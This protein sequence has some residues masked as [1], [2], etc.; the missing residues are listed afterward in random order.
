MDSDPR[1]GRPAT[2]T[3][4]EN[5]NRFRTTINKNHHITM[6]D[7]E[8][9]LRIGKNIVSEILT[10]DFGISCVAAKFVEYKLRITTWDLLEISQKCL[11]CNYRH[12]SWVYIVKNI[13][14]HLKNN[15]S[16]KRIRAE[17]L[18]QCSEFSLT[19]NMAQYGYLSL[20]RLN[21]KALYIL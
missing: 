17:A 10:Q 12:K 11:K 14:R 8:K 9:D 18:R 7:L 4:L 2:T 5:G 19:K 21:K 6:R 20:T 16:R 13:R 15:D 1:S 3:T